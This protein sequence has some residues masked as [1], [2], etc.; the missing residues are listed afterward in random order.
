MQEGFTPGN[1]E[2]GNGSEELAKTVRL[3]PHKMKGEGHFAAK[4]KKSEDAGTLDGI[5]AKEKKKR[6][7]D[8]KKQDKNANLAESIR[9]YERFCSE[10]RNWEDHGK[11]RLFGTHLY[12]VPEQMRELSGIHVVRAGL[13][14]GEQK[15]NRFEPAHALAL[16]LKPSEV[17]NSYELGEQTA[18]YLHGD[19]ISCGEN[20]KKGWVLLTTQG[21]SIGW[22][23][24]D[25]RQ[26]KNHYPKGLR[27]A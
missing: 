9:D 25:G 21:I 16:A 2:W 1:P 20:V 6:K 24:C 13:E 12:L 8:G 19:T 18:A 23:K 14:L 3:F 26:I 10:I 5:D 22:G 11:F 27:K 4:L 7:A 15:K 17:T